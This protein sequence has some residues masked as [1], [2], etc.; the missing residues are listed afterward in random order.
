MYLAFVVQ[1]HDAQSLHYDFHLEMMVKFISDFV[2]SGCRCWWPC[3]GG[4]WCFY[5][6]MVLG[7]VVVPTWISKKLGK[8]GD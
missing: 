3:F 7:A 8:R 5:G 1:M 2:P 6:Y 4:G